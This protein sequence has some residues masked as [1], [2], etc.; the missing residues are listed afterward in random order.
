VLIVGAAV[1][2]GELEAME[3]LSGITGGE[4]TLHPAVRA[5]KASPTAGRSISST[6]RLLEKSYSRAC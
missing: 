1:T 6:I 5:K 2:A 3:E 4:S